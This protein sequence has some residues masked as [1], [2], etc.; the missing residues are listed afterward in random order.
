MWKLSPSWW[1]SKHLVKSERWLTGTRIKRYEDFFAIDFRGRK[2]LEI[3]CGLA[4]ATRQIAQ[5][6]EEL[7]V[8]DISNTARIRASEAG[9]TAIIL[10]DSPHALPK[11]YFDLVVSHLVTHHL[12]DEELKYPLGYAIESLNGEGVFAVQFMTIP[13]F[14]E[15]MTIRPKAGTVSRTPQY[16]EQMVIANGGQVVRKVPVLTFN[17]L[18]TEGYDL[19]WHGFIIGR[20]GDVG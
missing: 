15:P 18:T 5:V 9:A 2:V 20:N 11:G 4:K 12:L 3:G 10:E 1:E 16:F 6:A 8:V 14:A 7:W 13:E 19:H 17:N